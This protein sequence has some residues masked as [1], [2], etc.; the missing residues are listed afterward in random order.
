[1]KIT[2]TLLLPAAAAILSVSMIAGC[3]KNNAA[4]TGGSAGTDPKNAAGGGGTF[5]LGSKPLTFTF[6]GNYDWYNMPAWGE[7]A[8]SKWIKENKKVDIKAVSS[9]GAAAQK[10]NTMIASGDLP[11]VVWLERSGDVEKLRAADML[12][13]LDDYINKYPNLKKWLG[14]AGLNML[15]ASD[16]KIYGFPNWYTN[17]PNGNAGYVVNKKIYKEL[18]S[19]KLETTDDLYNYLKAVKE[20]Y[21]NVIPF[22]PHL[23]K[24]G[25][26]LDVIYSAFA[27]NHP[28]VYVGN[29][30]VPSGD[31]LTSIFTDPVFRETMQYESKLFREKACWIRMR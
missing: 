21:P 11:D 22:E 29:R 1:M 24:D 25:Q 13:P 3:E 28:N 4:E 20:K 31:K 8:A 26:G 12:V 23:G 7:D 10:L 19:P 16:G 2:K 5:E 14:E 27:E 9:G 17:R 18:G 6:Y 15:R 30:A